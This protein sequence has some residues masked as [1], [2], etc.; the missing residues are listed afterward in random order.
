M[1]ARN[2]LS[3]PDAGVEL[4]RQPLDVF[5]V[6]AIAT[7]PDLIEMSQR[8][9]M[10]ARLVAIRPDGQP[11][12]PEQILPLRRELI[13]LWVQQR[14]ASGEVNMLDPV[15]IWSKFLEILPLMMDSRAIPDIGRAVGTP[16]VA[17]GR[18]FNPES[19]DYAHGLFTCSMIFLGM[20]K[21]ITG[22]RFGRLVAI[23]PTEKR[24]SKCV[25]WE[26]QC[27]CGNR[28]F[29]GVNNVT[30]GNSIGC[31]CV[32]RERIR[33]RAFIHGKSHTPLYFIW[34]AMRDRCNNPRNKGYESY[35][36]R[37]IT[38]CSRWDDYTAFVSDMGPR[39]PG[40]TI[41]RINNSG[42]YCPENCRWATRLEQA[43]NRR[44]KRKRIKPVHDQ[45][46]P[47]PLGKQ[48]TVRTVEIQR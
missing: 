38:V 32:R 18:N 42:S 5:I 6:V 9:C 46:I 28:T 21:D 8:L 30:T 48:T 20:T 34:S 19:I 4:L 22:L 35:G 7:G 15:Q 25:V 13:K 45:E 39:P 16:A 14:F 12:A 41:E 27:D 11:L 33:A 31:G 40:L 2:V 44:P 24:Q 10:P 36:G 26:F 23:R 3:L 37:G 43:A 47:M 17:V 1:I 29:K